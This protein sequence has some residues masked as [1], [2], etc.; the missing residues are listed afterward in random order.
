MLQHRSECVDTTVGPCLTALQCSHNCA[1][2]HTQ[3]FGLHKYA[4]KFTNAGMA[5]FV[6]DYRGWGG[7]GGEPRHWLSAKRH[8]AGGLLPPHYEACMPDKQTHVLN[9][10]MFGVISLGTIQSPR[11]VSKPCATSG[12]QVLSFNTGSP[13]QHPLRWCVLLVA[14]LHDLPLL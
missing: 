7:S 3:D 14:H 5:A 12:C 2:T 1:H 6:F 10:C 4:D 9:N 8:M 11:M 13:T